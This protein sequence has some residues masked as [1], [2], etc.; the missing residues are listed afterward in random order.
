MDDRTVLNRLS[1]NRQTGQ[2]KLFF[3]PLRTC[4]Y[5]TIIRCTY[6]RLGISRSSDY[7]LGQGI[8]AHGNIAKEVF[9]K[10]KS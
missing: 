3:D 8:L 7:Y 2:R 5:M 4:G 1:V 6:L 10:V 9:A